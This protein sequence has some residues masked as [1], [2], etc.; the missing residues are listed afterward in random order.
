M[1]YCGYEAAVEYHILQQNSRYNGMSY[2]DQGD[3][4]KF[5]TFTVL[6]EGVSEVQLDTPVTVKVNIDE[7]VCDL[8]VD[9]LLMVTVD[10]IRTPIQV[11]STSEGLFLFELSV[12][13]HDVLVRRGSS[14]LIVDL[15]KPVISDVHS[16]GDAIVWRTDD[17]SDGIVCYSEKIDE[18]LWDWKILGRDLER[19][20]VHKVEVP[21]ETR[22]A[23]YAVASTNKRGMTGWYEGSELSV[24]R[25]FGVRE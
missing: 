4:L 16:D 15:S 7:E 10:G 19:S 17:M 2:D 13:D 25:T 21:K 12:G 3:V 14:G 23:R 1:Y 9:D 22:I 11:M 24:I 20:Q 18:P 5:C 6:P 8:K